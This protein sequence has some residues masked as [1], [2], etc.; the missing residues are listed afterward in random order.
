LSAHDLCEHEQRH[1][2]FDK[3][4]W[5]FHLVFSKVGNIIKSVAVLCFCACDRQ[6]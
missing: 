2:A 3:L 6:C 1:S 4:V 5:E